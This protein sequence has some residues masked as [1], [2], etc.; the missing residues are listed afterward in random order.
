[1]P[2]AQAAKDDGGTQL[3]VVIPVY[4]NAQVLDQ[5]HDR[6]TASLEALALSYQIILVND[7]SR[8]TSG[9]VIDR[10]AR[11]DPRIEAIHLPRNGGQNRAICQGMRHNRAD[12][13]VVMD[14]DLQDRPEHLRRL[15][16]A[17]QAPGQAVFLRRTTPYQGHVRMASSRMFKRVLQV[18][19]GLDA[20]AGTYFVIDR[21]IASRLAEEADK[22][23]VVT[24]LVAH[25]AKTVVYVDGPRDEAI[26][27]SNYSTLD[28]IA[29][30]QRA[31]R[32]AVRARWR[33]R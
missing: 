16:A 14:A 3:A 11:Q 8:D 9:E 18:L 4:N 31:I 33:A 1:V 32:C 20:R 24:V 5:L 29:Y 28:R 21:N 27:V 6:L 13:V 7:S 26:S 30:G 12:K 2:P 10:L 19:T 25:Y 17:Q 23:P 22:A 15:L